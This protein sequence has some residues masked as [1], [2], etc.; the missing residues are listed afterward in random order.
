MIE[1]GIVVSAAGPWSGPLLATAGLDIPLEI[2][3][4][5]VL[6]FKADR[7]YQPGLPVVKD[8]TTEN[9]M[10]FRPA[11]GAVVLVGTGDYGDPVRY[12]DAMDENIDSA[13]IEHQGSQLA[14]RM[15]AF[16]DSALTDSWIGPYDITPDWN[17][18]LGPVGSVEGLYVAFGFSGHGFKLAPAIGQM[19]AQTVLNKPPEIDL[20]PYR[21]DRFAAGEWLSGSYGIGSIS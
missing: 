17:P 21:L 16:A 3:R 15:P 19:L 10:Y 8:L 14:R 4:H 13:F 18:V 12:A 1:T 11:S 6:T 5:K 2:S 9:K 7:P 20:H